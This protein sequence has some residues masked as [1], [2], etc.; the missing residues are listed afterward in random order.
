M[1]FASPLVGAAVG[2]HG[3]AIVTRDGGATWTP[4]PAGVDRMLADLEWLDPAH[5]SVV[6]ERGLVL[7]R[8][9]D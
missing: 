1:K 3:A 6:G 8:R 5:A 2:P 7:A 9:P 4:R